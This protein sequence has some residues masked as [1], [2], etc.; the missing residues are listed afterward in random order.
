MTIIS[1]QQPELTAKLERLAVEQNTTP[2]ALLHA[3]VQDFLNKASA[4]KSNATNGKTAFYPELEREIKAFAQ[5]KPELLQKYKGRVVAIYQGQVVAVGD[6]R[7]EV[8]GVVL[9]NLG[10]VPCYI[11]W[12][13]E[14]TPRRVRITSTWITQ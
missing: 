7:M 10:P 14:E 6:D 13:E 2:E 1:L 8:L 12:V 5:L 9:E 4:N 3:A 11:E